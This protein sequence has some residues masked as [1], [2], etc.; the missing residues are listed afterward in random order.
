MSMFHTR[1]FKF[2]LEQLYLENVL[3]CKVVRQF[4]SLYKILQVEISQEA[5]NIDLCIQ[6]K[7]LLY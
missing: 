5:Y 2:G 6:T 4:K 1:Y 7:I 3:H